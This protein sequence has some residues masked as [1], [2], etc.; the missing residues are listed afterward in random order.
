[1][2]HFSKFWDAEHL[3]SLL[4]FVNKQRVF[5]L[6]NHN[7]YEKKSFSWP[8]FFYRA[9]VDIVLLMHFAHTAFLLCQAVFFLKIHFKNIF[10]K[11]FLSSDRT[12]LIVSIHAFMQKQKHTHTPRVF[13]LWGTVLSWYSMCYAHLRNTYSKGQSKINMW[14]AITKWAKSSNSCYSKW[15]QIQIFI[16]Q[17]LKWCMICGYSSLFCPA[18]INSLCWFSFIFYCFVTCLTGYIFVCKLATLRSFCDSRSHI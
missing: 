9:V 12:Y 3:A 11:L 10:E 6:I 16:M 13:I 8:W 7:P 4:V 1:M 18:K 2:R 5:M 17:A 14:P 15:L